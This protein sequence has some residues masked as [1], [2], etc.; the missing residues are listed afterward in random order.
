MKMYVSSYVKDGLRWVRKAMS[1]DNHPRLQV[2]QVKDGCV[3]AANGFQIH[4]ARLGQ[5]GCCVEDGYYK[6]A[7]HKDMAF[8]EPEEVEKYPDIDSIFPVGEPVVR[9]AATAALLRKVL[10]MPFSEFES[11]LVVFELYANVDGHRQPYVIRSS[12]GDS[13]ALLMPAHVKN[14]KGLS[15]CLWR[16]EDEERNAWQAGCNE[17]IFIFESGTPTENHFARCPYCGGPLREM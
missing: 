7:F 6:M 11:P 5:N 9:F 17:R 16:L 14:E 10:A 1:D 13:V 8:F 3:I 12:K 4:K 15:E 2:V